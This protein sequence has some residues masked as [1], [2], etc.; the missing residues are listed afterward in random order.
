[1]VLGN[2]YQ[3]IVHRIF[4]RF[5]GLEAGR[6]GRCDLDGGPS[7]RVTAVACRTCFYRE[8][9]KTNQG[10]VLTA[11]QRSGY[12]GCEG[13]QRASG[14]GLREVGGARYGL[15]QIVFIHV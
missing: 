1:M 3:R 8:G 15:D 11:L 7:L 12:D 6:L 13:F 2:R 5:T 10:D 14:S 4:Q 9:A